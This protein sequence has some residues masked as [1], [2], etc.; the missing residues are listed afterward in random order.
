M[1]GISMYGC[2]ENNLKN[3]DVT[4]PYSKIVCFI[5]VSGSGKS[6]VVFDTL[7][8]EGKRRYIESLGVNESY[9]LSKIKKPDADYF[10]G[11]PPAIAL[12][13][14]SAVRNSRSTVGSISQIAYFLQVLFSSCGENRGKLTLTPS[15]FNLNSPAG[16]CEEC[17]GTGEILRFDETLIWPDQKLSMAKGGIKLSG[18]KPGSMKMNFYNSFLQQYGFD[19]N[20]PIE[21]YS[22]EVKVALLFGQKKNKKYKVEFPGII[23]ESEK[24]YKTTKSLKTREKLESFM[25]KSKCEG[26]SGTGYNPKILDITIAGRN[27]DYYMNLPIEEMLL[28]ME[29]MHFD[30]SRDNIFEQIKGKFFR[31]LRLCVDLGVGYLSLARKST[32]LSGGEIQRLKLVSQISSEISGVVYVLD[33]P[34]CGLHMSDIDKV[35]KAICKLNNIGNKNTVVLVEHTAKIIN[36]CDYIFE[37]GPGAGVN[38]GKIVSQGTVEE[39]KNDANSISGKYLSGKERA[40]KVN[41]NNDYIIGKSLK[42]INVNSNN[43][44]NINIEIPLGAMVCFT[45]VSGSG[46]TSL[47]FDSLYQS[48][49][50]KKNIGLENVEN[51]DLV[52]HIVL[53]DQSPIGKSSRS[54]PVTYLDIWEAIRKIFSEQEK[55]KKMKISDSMFSF[56]VDGGRCEKCKGEGYVKINMGF[57]PEMPVI[58]DM[59]D[60]KRFKSKILDVKY[61]NLSIFDVLELSVDEAIG[62]FAENQTVKLK[63]LAIQRVGLG[64]IKLGQ[65]TSTLSGG[66]SQRLKLAAEIAKTNTAGTMVI[67]DEPTKGL[68]FQ[69]VKK[70]LSVMRELVKKGNSLLIIEHNLDVISSCDYVIDIGPGG[71]RNGGCVVGVGTPMQIS[72]KNTV[73][74]KVLNE[75]YNNLST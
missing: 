38:G 65:S 53:C 36:A 26:C 21:N 8:A 20:T 70:L 60:G 55:A 62:Y 71:G 75:Y 44:K 32:T 15:M 45:G 4:I 3:I 12:V 50:Y 19:V 64:Y 49:H 63:L 66:E 74:G 23:C 67:F 59:C 31:N 7:Y 1:N 35:L 14:N 54:C 5:G 25:T 48:L 72:K 27:I 6:T 33:E 47:V 37:I 52:K 18:A 68:H 34:S 43:L 11:I 17:N 39:I 58:C 28:V 24:Q 46:K 2:K 51:R 57:L 40:S 22:N 69:D 10:V 61:K 41:Y 13:Q 29:K 73:T 42:L 16:G 30:D 9:F 56:N